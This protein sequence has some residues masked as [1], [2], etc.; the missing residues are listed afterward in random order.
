ML[1]AIFNIVPNLTILG[2]LEMILQMLLNFHLAPLYIDYYDYYHIIISIIIIIIITMYKGT[3]L[4]G[5]RKD[6][7]YHMNILSVCINLGHKV[8]CSET[9]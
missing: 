7:S 9:S 1:R 8:C 2:G 6:L 3:K 5:E 4:E